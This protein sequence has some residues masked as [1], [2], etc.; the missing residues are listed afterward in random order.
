MRLLLTPTQFLLWG[1]GWTQWAIDEAMRHL[2]QQDPYY[3]VTAEM[4]TG[5]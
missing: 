2:D 4:L 5:Q 3:G 1:S